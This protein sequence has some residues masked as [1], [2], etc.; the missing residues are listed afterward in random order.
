MG[1]VQLLLE[2][3]GTALSF[4]NLIAAFAGAIMGLIVGA[5]PGIGSLAGVALLLPLTFKMNPTT[6]IIMLAALYYSN[7]YGGS[8]SAILL[9]IPGDSPAIMTSLDGYP[10]SRKGEAG[11]ALFTASVSS[12]IGGT[13]GIIMLTFIG[14]LAAKWGLSF[15]PAELTWLIVL[16]L[17]SIGWLIG[18][19]PAAGLLATALGMMIATVGFDKALGQPRFAFGN[20][21]LFSG[22]AF[23]PLVI[24]MFGFGQVI[25]MVVN[26]DNYASVSSKKL[27][28]KESIVNKDEAKRIAPVAVRS[29]LLG[30][31][32]G[33][34]P[35]AGA[36]M[37]AFL[38]YVTEKKIGKNKDQM[39]K[40]AV[41]GVAA[42]EAANN[43]AAMGAFAPLLSLGIPGSGT[44]AVLLGGLMMWGLQPG[45]LLFKNN[46]DFVWGLIGSMYIGNIICL[47]IAILSIPILMKVV[48]VP[49]S[50]MV[51][52]ISS[53]C[54]IG[55]YSVN[56]SMFDVYLMIGAGVL[57]YLMSLA[58]IP[59]APLLLS[60]VL[61]PMLEMYIRQSF[62]ISGGSL[63]V[64]I[65]SPISKVLCTL[66][67]LFSVTPILLKIF[68]KK[69]PVDMSEMDA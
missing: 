39:G 65:Q 67:I 42:A 20:V 69:P 18:D 40:G 25:D 30:T 4:Q 64:F 13:I 6:A 27:S 31:F 14:P 21:N 57:A 51:P 55:T 37:G 66:I 41:E 11:K 52:L 15:G 36:T 2:G 46:P 59:A 48:T 7:M 60:F 28:I 19:K 10:M 58:D 16:A 29:G 9:N 38:S 8:F 26:R 34:L 50:L 3:I 24:G 63:G 61:T 17:T 22:V 54:I 1:N 32:I 49:S 23:I 43:G 68:N 5:M 47:I 53:I 33:I 62:D 44:S 12:F 35:G 56:N 45:P